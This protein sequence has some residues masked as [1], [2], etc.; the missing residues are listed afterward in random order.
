M[1]CTISEAKKRIL[2]K[3]D[4]N[5]PDLS[6]P[7]I[8]W[9]SVGIGKTEMII[10][11]V[12]ERM[13][14]DLDVE[15]NKK[16]KKCNEESVT[17]TDDKSRKENSDKRKKLREEYD[18]KH[19]L[20]NFDYISHELLETIDPHCLVL[21]LAERPIEQLQGVIV[22]SMAREEKFASFVMPENLVKIKDVPWGI[23]FLDE[24]DKASE[25]K[26]GAA[27][28]LLENNVIGDMQLGKGWYVIAAANREDDSFL[29][30]PIPPELRNRCANI[31]VEHDLN[32][33]M[34][35]AYKHGIRKDIQAFH[36]F[37][38]GE[39]LFKYSAEDGNYS[40]PTPR[41][42]ANVS[43]VIDRAESKINKNNEKEVE[44]F[45]RH[46]VRKELDDFVGEQAQLEFFTYR[47]LYLKFNFKEILSGKARIPRA[48][49]GS[50][51]EQSVISDQ[52]VAAFAMA[53]QVL[54][55]H[56]GKK[57][58]SGFVQNNK[59]MKNFIRFIEDLAPEI[60][61]LYLQM[62]HTTK[63]MNI[64][65]DSGMANKLMEEM[66]QYLAAA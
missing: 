53:D 33:W 25:S 52:C 38:G 8:L 45:Y 26:F 12:C 13:L 18:K 57:S 44:D 4:W 46:V 32:S 40:F 55:E 21:R 9:G 47:D 62:I 61:T 24:L 49:S 14:I 58:S 65:L 20:L 50:N 41:S 64:L 56:L 51:D 48:G 17:C 5:N 31:E 37:K 34:L 2:S 16:F 43:R 35:W 66:V 1:A 15:F 6:Y 10:S 59:V 3:W 63:I 27:T 23:V 28:H 30:N 11:L 54:P 7:V 60:R 19:K 22:P 39:Y 42:W 29:S 36:K